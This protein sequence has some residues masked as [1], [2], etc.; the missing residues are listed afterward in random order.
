MVNRNQK[1]RTYHLPR[2]TEM[3]KLFWERAFDLVGTD[4]VSIFIPIFL[5]RLH[6]SLQHI[7]WFYALAGLFMVPLD[8]L[9]FWL[10]TK[11]GANRTM[12]IGNVGNVAF[13]LMLFLL[14]SLH[15]PLWIIAFWRGFYSAIYYPAFNA[16]FIAA[17]AHNKTGTQIGLLS[18]ITLAL[19]GI[20]P[21]VGGLLAASLGLTWVYACAVILIIIGSLPLL[22]GKEHLHVTQ[23]RL[24]LIPWRQEYKDF[25][26]NGLYNI[27]GFVEQIIWPLLISIIISSY[28]G[29]GIVGSVIVICSI[30]ISL[31]VGHKE[32]RVGERRY[33][34]QGIMTGAI[35]DVGKLLAADPVGVVGV[36]IISGA[37]S[38]LLAN[39]FISR[40]YKNADSEYM[41]EYTFGME[42]THS[43][44]WAL[45]FLLLASLAAFLSFKAVLIFGIVL[46]IPATL[47]VRWIRS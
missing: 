33:I 5:L 2:L 29:I 15:E 20:A 18:A 3:K 14:P 22:V 46:A 9:G 11:V 45:Y 16:N 35:G 31:Y 13:Y 25:L 38:A 32:D 40:Y 28:A 41:L 44:I 10:I 7:F 26:A 30:V 12:V 34:N 36:N 21:A 43:V 24:R 39:S 6:Y 23:F 47:G 42:V 17:R 4:L 19:S 27:P 37:S 8:L 1:Y